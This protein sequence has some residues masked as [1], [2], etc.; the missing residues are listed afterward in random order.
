MDGS[1][2]ECRTQSILRQWLRSIPSHLCTITTGHRRT[3]IACLSRKAHLRLH[4]RPS[5][6]THECTITLLKA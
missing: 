6:L 3:I 1:P 4:H 5:N 2:N